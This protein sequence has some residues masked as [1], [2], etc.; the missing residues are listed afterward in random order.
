MN[1]GFTE[2]MAD[3]AVVQIIDNERIVKVPLKPGTNRVEIHGTYVTPEF[4]AILPTAII[5]AIVITSLVVTT[6][7]ALK[8]QFF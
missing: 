5:A 7:L 1:D 3:D 6:R 4:G 2:Q 8:R